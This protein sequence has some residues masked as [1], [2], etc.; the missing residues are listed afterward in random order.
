M[1]NDREVTIYD[2]AEELKIS[3]APVSRGLK[4]DPKV[5]KKTKKKT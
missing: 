2:I 5:S 4:D 1:Y 3:A